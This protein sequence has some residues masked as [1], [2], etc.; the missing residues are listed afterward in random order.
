MSLAAWIAL[1]KGVLDFPED[2]LK[3]VKVLESTPIEKRD[4]IMACSEKAWSSFKETG[5][6]GD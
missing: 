4:A 3:L 6:P 1:I 2:I 5:R